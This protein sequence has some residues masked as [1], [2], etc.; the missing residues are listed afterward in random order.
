M[1]EPSALEKVAVLVF[2]ECVMKTYTPKEHRT[3]DY[4]CIIDKRH[5]E[6]E[7]FSPQENIMGIIRF[8]DERYVNEIGRDFVQ[9][10]G[11]RPT[12]LFPGNSHFSCHTIANS[13]TTVYIPKT[14]RGIIENA[15]FYYFNQLV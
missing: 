3:D 9:K 1:E 2:N 7:P 14:Q 10:Y 4:V 13:K 6:I 15:F 5:K 11:I 8:D 12:E